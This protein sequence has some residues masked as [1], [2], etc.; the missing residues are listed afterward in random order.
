MKLSHLHVLNYRG[1]RDVSIPLSSFVC[2]TGENNGGKSSVLQSLSL[3]LSGSALKSTDYFDTSQPITIA[4]TLTDV[5]PEDLKL[6][7]DEHRDRIGELVVVKTLILVRLYGTDGKS[8]LG[9]FGLVPKEPRYSS[10]NVATLV[11]GKKGGQLKDAVLGVFPELTGQVNASTT[12]GAVKEFILKLG[13]ALP[14]E[15]KATQ[16]IALPTGLDKSVIPMLPERIYIPA[17]KDLADDTKT[18]ETSSF[19]KILA[20]VMKAIEPLLTEEKDLFEK[21]SKKLTRVLGADGKVEDERLSEIR[22]IEQTI[23]RYVRESFS[24]VSLEIEIPPPELKSVLATARIF[25]DDGARGPLELKGDGLRRAVVFSILRAYVELNRAATKEGEAEEG[26]SER[27]Y[28]LLFEEPELFLHPDAQKILFDALG[29]FSKKNH[30]VVTTHSPLFLGPDAIATFIRLSKAVEAGVAKPFTKSCHID[31]T[32]I[33]P[34]DEFQIICFENNSAAFF[35][36]RIVLVEGD[37]DFIAFPHI[38]EVLNGDWNC[39]SRSVAFVRVGG[40]GSI[41]KYRSF[42]AKFDVPVFVITD[43]DCLQDDFDK[44]DPS[45]TAKTLRAELIQKVDA[46]NAA[47]GVGVIAN[48][49]DL[50]RAQAKPEIRRLWEDV[51]GAKA[52]YDTDKTKLSV[53][54]AAV[55]AFFSWEKKNIRLDCIRKAEQTDIQTTKMALIWELRKKGVFVLERGAL[56]DYYPTGLTGPDKPSRAQAFREVFDTRDKILPL[57]S[58]QTCPVT[59]KVSTEFEFVC[60]T[61]FG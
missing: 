29:V 48:N 54:D 23:Q 12:Q 26:Q 25:A 17:V 41:A 16:F 50:K 24:N 60:S 8:Q 44:L 9:Y 28:L 30:V 34:R 49:D 45:E 19:G 32:G 55:G 1:L 7:A 46:A 56:D 47:A 5:T 3:F 61:I 10:E 42:F 57:S 53:L 14:A 51:R 36:K 4:V 38:A 20:I 22:A 15:D 18:A 40:K 35:S 59:G 58:Q 33:K 2:V 37:S 52:E 43:L 6:L 11:A 27:G 21:L 13:D 31:L 39:R